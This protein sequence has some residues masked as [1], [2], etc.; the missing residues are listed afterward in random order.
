MSEFDQ[1][2]GH[3]KCQQHDFS[4]EA[5]VLAAQLLVLTTPAKITQSASHGTCTGA[6]KTCNAWAIQKDLRISNQRRRSLSPTKP[7]YIFRCGETGLYAFTA[8]SKGRILPSRLY[9]RVQWRL[10]R[11]ILLRLDRNSPQVK[12]LL[13]VVDAIEM[14]GFHLVHASVDEQLLQLP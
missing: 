14:H 8:D 7:I 9:P 5:V 13:T 12:I 10:Q 1:E 6:E 11:R 4:A 3:K 2:D